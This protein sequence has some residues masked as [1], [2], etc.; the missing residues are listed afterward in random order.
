MRRWELLKEK[1]A[2]LY[3]LYMDIWYFKTKS[4]KLK[5]VW[6]KDWLSY[7]DSDCEDDDFKGFSV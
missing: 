7:M 4:K 1:E 6:I 5:E 3:P 2:N